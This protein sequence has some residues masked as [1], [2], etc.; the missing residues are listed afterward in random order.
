[1][2]I[3][4][5]LAITSE[6]VTARHLFVINMLAITSEP[7]TARHLF[8][9]NMLAITSE[10]VTTRHLFIINMLAITS[11]PVTTRHLFI[12]TRLE[13]TYWFNRREQSNFITNE[14]HINMAG[15]DIVSSVAVEMNSGVVIWDNISKPRDIGHL[16]GFQLQVVLSYNSMMLKYTSH[17]CFIYYKIV[18]TFL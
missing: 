7:V 9:I 14:T 5:M 17:V 16:V 4:N 8:I 1:M 10:P 11:E 13:V 15:I 6:P 2:F 18:S 12:T 3:I